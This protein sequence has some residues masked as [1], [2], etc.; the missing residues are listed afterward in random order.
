MMCRRLNTSGWPSAGS[1]AASNRVL[2]QQCKAHAA[3]SRALCASKC[4]PQPCPCPTCNPD[5]SVPLVQLTMQAHSACCHSPLKHRGKGICRTKLTHF[6]RLVR[7]H[8][9]ANRL[10]TGL[11]L[12]RWYAASSAGLCTY[13]LWKQQ[14]CL[15][16]R[17]GC[18]KHN[19]TAPLSHT[20][21]FSNQ[22]ARF[23]LLEHLSSKYRSTVAELSP[24]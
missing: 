17:L 21:F 14:S 19:N 8:S 12:K 22:A 3:A 23:A 13:I 18:C 5:A 15:G 20:Q 1:T 11:C 24:T 4:I 7:A 10:R 6:A 9:S 2:S 16:R